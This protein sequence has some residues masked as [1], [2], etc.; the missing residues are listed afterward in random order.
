MTDEILIVVGMNREARIAAPRGRVI[1]G[2]TGLT[3]AL[4]LRPSA[5][6][7]LGV[8]GALDPVL[9]IGDV[10]IADAVVV[11]ARRL[12]ADTAWT[13]ALRAALPASRA[14]DIV[15]GDVIVDSPGAKAALR[16]ASGAV[17]VDMESH[18][19][20]LAAEAAGIPFAV[21]RTVSDTAGRALPGAAVAGFKPDG[22]ADIWA[23]IRAL[24]RRPWELPALI[25]TGLDAERAFR[26]LEQAAHALAARP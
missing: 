20:A 12:A 13:K 1:V 2:T 19:V 22:E 4:T 24:A 5:I 6:I 21:L 23:V 15:G 16:R 10:L 3:G 25:R 11:G 17:G 8:C 26:T 18:A 9:E 7:S 14:G